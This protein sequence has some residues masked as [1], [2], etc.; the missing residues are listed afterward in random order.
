ML[1]EAKPKKRCSLLDR[2]CYRVQVDGNELWHEDDT[3]GNFLWHTIMSLCAIFL[4]GIPL[5]LVMLFGLAYAAFGE[6]PLQFQS[7]YLSTSFVRALLC[8]G[9]DPNA[10]RAGAYSPLCCA[11][12]MGRT[13]AAELL[14]QHGADIDA[15]SGKRCETALMLAGARGDLTMT[16][17]LLEHGASVG[18]QNGERG[19]TA[20]HNAVMMDRLDVAEALLAFGANVD[21][22]GHHGE[23]ALFVA[24]AVEPFGRVEKVAATARGA[25]AILTL[26]LQA[27]SDINASTHPGI[28]ALHVAAEHGTRNTVE[29]LLRHG[30]DA[31]ARTTK[32]ETPLDRAVAAGNVGIA[33]LLMS[34]G[35]QCGEL[36]D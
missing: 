24:C 33:D 1:A 8:L 22:T 18:A 16:K 20:L 21:A 27:G 29:L 15:K 30:A 12:G 25:D 36:R 2:Y 28:T 23:T 35:G 5:G 9:F 17:F 13:R 32:G 11:V 6:T 3:P 7:S 4:Y 31:N 26:L 34:H 10:H 19:F 14:L